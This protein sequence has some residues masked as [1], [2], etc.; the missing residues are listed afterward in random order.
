MRLK[1]KG[2]ELSVSYPALCVFSC[3]IILNFEYM[4]C[5]LAVTF[6]ETA[7]LTVLALTESKVS[8]LEIT[9]FDFKILAKS[10]H[11][12]NYKSD[13]TVSAAGPAANILL[14]LIFLNISS[15]FALI[16]LFIGV[17]NL[18][19]ASGTDGGQIIYLLLTERFS[20]KTASVILDV[21]TLIVSIPMFAVGILVLFKSKYNFSLLLISLFLLTT[22]FVKEDKYL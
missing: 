10:R 4:Y 18:L 15:G 12:L 19:P 9:L 3:L 22:L 11:R 21:L 8:G 7:H 6:H 14:F 2:F 1:I 16:N 20:A 13:I 5:I 17:F